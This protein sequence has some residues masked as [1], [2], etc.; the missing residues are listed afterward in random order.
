MRSIISAA[1]RVT[2]LCYAAVMVGCGGAETGTQVKVTEAEVQKRTQGIKDA[3][4]AGMYNNP[5]SKSAKAK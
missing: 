1:L 2:V 4:K 3:M 5:N